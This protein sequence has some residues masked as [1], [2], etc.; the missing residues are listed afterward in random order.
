VH[1]FELVP[2]ASKEVKLSVVI[3]S[4]DVS[5]DPAELVIAV[6]TLHMI[7]SF[8]FFYRG[9]ASG[10]RSHIGRLNPNLELFIIVAFL[11]IRSATFETN[12]LPAI[13]LDL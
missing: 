4:I 6:N 13:T 8:I 9:F 7:A 12:Q 10:A 2:W 1:C 5:T 3:F 11:M